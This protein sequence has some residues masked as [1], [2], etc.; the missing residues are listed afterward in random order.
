MKYNKIPIL[1]NFHEFKEIEKEDILGFIELPEDVLCR[2]AFIG[3]ALGEPFYLNFIVT[4]NEP[5][6][7]EFFIT[8]KESKR[9]K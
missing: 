5:V 7:T 9:Y 4:K 3:Q 6:S 2:M 8:S 1:K